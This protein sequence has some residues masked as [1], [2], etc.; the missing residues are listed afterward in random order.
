MEIHGNTLKYVEIHGN[1][2]RRGDKG[3]RDEIL[4]LRVTT[5]RV[6]NLK[7]QNPIAETETQNTEL[8]TQNSEP[9]IQ[10]FEQ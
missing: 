2:G 1:R 3:S 6:A 10:N 8:R 5:R 7:I 9:R 4:T